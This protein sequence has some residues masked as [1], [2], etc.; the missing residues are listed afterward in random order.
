M[1]E[2]DKK[3][4]LDAVRNAIKVYSGAEEAFGD[5]P[6]LKIDPKGLTA[7]PVAEVEVPE[8][9]DGYDYYPLL[10]LAAMDPADPGRWIADEEA[11]QSVEC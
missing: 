9:E 3:T 8:E 10:D 6:Y 11:L 7:E 5:E 1:T 2:N 4:L